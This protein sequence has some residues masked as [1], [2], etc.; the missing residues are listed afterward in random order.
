MARPIAPAASTAEY[1]PPNKTGFSIFSDYGQ[2][3]DGN[4]CVIDKVS[5]R[6]TNTAGKELLYIA[7]LEQYLHEIMHVV[8][9][10]FITLLFL[11]FHEEKFGGDSRRTSS[12]S[13]SGAA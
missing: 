8:R 4:V 10:K 12:Q 6:F 2:P 1:G 7:D 5:V 13:C 11:A 3:P 9:D